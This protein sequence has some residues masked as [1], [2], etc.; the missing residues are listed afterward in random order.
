MAGQ[1][2]ANSLRD[3][4]RIADPEGRNIFYFWDDPSRLPEDFEAKIARTADLHPD[5]R[6]ILAG[7][8]A[9]TELLRTTYPRL[10]AIYPHIRIPASRSDI[11]RMALLRRFGGW[12][13]DCDMHLARS[14]DDLSGRKPVAIRRNDRAEMRKTYRLMNGVLYMPRGHVLPRRVLTR[15]V[16]NLDR[17]ETLYS[18]LNF[19]GPMVLSA[20]AETMPQNRLRILPATRVFRREGALFQEERNETG[21]TWRIQEG[22]GLIGGLAPDLSVFPA[23][24]WDKHAVALAGYVRQYDLLHHI[25]ALAEAR[26]AY[27]DQMRFRSLLRQALE[28]RFADTVARKR[29]QAR[30]PADVVQALLSTAA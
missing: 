19:A 23:K 28:A 3:L 17:P 4:E 14:L 24:L 16:R 2:Q 9:T 20:V 25:P 27:R 21:F 8:I 22:F 1:M 11:A 29:A 10:A 5:W 7:D 15:I 30:A 13:L 18:V 26:P 6:V 12:Y